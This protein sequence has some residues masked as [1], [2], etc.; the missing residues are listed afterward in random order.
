MSKLE[1]RYHLEEKRV[2]LALVLFFNCCLSLLFRVPRSFGGDFFLH[3]WLIRLQGYSWEANHIPAM[4]VSFPPVGDLS[5]VGL[6]TGGF[7]YQLLGLI[8]ALGIPLYYCAVFAYFVVIN[9][10]CVQSFLLARHL[11]VHLILA[12][13]IFFVPFGF[14][15]PIG[16]GFGRGGY[17]S[18]LAG[19][20]IVASSLSAFKYLMSEERHGRIIKSLSVLSFLIAAT[21]LPS[22]II[23]CVFSI[24][25]INLCV[26]IQQGR[27]GVRTARVVNLSIGIGVL[28]GAAYW[29]PSILWSRSATFN[30]S[31]PFQS[32]VSS[33]FASARNLW[34]FSRGVPSSHSDIWHSW[35]GDGFT[36][37][38]SLIV[39][40]PTYLM[41]FLVVLI[42]FVIRR[43]NFR[44]IL[45]FLL[46]LIL[47]Y[48]IIMRVSLWNVLP[49]ELRSVQ[50]TFRLLY[51]PIPF[52]VVA[53]CFS[54]KKFSLIGVRLLLATAFFFVVFVNVFQSFEQIVNS[55]NL[56][57]TKALKDSPPRWQYD[58]SPDTVLDYWPDAPFWYAASEMMSKD[59]VLADPVIN[60]HCQE[61]LNS[62]NWESWP[63]NFRIK[64]LNNP[65]SCIS[66]PLRLPMDWI[67]ISTNLKAIGRASNLDVVLKSD[68]GT[69]AKTV[70]ISL[71]S[72]MY[73]GLYISLIGLLVFSRGN[74]LARSWTRCA[75]GNFKCKK[76]QD[77]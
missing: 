53:I 1:R 66:L 29:F 20:L 36:E 21:H 3:L 22:F 11:G 35:I 16:D 58:V 26:F 52:V 77:I 25:L 24:P 49:N 67:S 46:P 34:S 19:L 43:T 72:P 76:R 70:A 2:L 8:N 31:D 13:L 6:F 28:M 73:N 45:S 23:Y 64:I 63:A 41:I 5:V 60:K 47:I 10:V 12:S 18:M 62:M 74:W 17:S 38:T 68:S 59:N 37:A 4:L 44:I 71:H 50:Y 55:T 39:T 61:S 30:N 75:F 40:Q 56:S 48:T 69:E 57:Y 65:N 15:W 27:K 51:I 14:A 7:S 54:F 9:Y 32:G 33:A 42:L